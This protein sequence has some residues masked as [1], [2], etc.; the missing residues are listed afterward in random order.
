MVTQAIWPINYRALAAQLYAHF[1]C[2]RTSKTIF[3]D[4]NTGEEYRNRKGIFYI[5]VQGVCNAD[6]LLVNVVARWTGSSHDTTVINNSVLKMQ[7]EEGLFG[8]RWLIG[9]SAYPCTSYLLTPLINPT[10]LPEHRYNEAH[11]TS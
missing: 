6:L 11:I 2:G 4:L 3:S 10:S 1:C 7:C 5:I 8:K 9:D